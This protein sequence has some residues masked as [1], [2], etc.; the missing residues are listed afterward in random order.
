MGTGAGRLRACLGGLPGAGAA[1][2]EGRPAGQC[3]DQRKLPRPRPPGSGRATRDNPPTEGPAPGNSSGRRSKA[4]A[5]RP[6]SSYPAGS[7]SR[8]SPWRSRGYRGLCSPA[9]S[10]RGPRNSGR[11]GGLQKCTGQDP[12]WGVLAL[13]PWQPCSVAV[14]GHPPPS[15][16]QLEAD[17]LQNFCPRGLVGTLPNPGL[18]P[19]CFGPQQSLLLCSQ[20]LSGCEP[21]RLCH[22]QCWPSPPQL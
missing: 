19:T 3:G 10:L 22:V 20:L 17:W 6:S 11:G 18:P 16:T 7:S 9:L 1:D 12:Q 4:P 8:S 21:G 13:G 14:D 5:F 15:R 2:G